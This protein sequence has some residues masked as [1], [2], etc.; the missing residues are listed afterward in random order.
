VRFRHRAVGARRAQPHRPR[1][2]RVAGS[3]RVP[4]PR[5]AASRC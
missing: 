3:G 1:R 4:S 2:C 5:L